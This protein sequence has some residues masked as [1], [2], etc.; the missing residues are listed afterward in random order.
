MTLS[1]E[2]LETEDVFSTSIEF[3]RQQILAVLECSC[4]ETSLAVFRAPARS[5]SNSGQRGRT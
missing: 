4:L 1:T 2:K 3:A 5:V